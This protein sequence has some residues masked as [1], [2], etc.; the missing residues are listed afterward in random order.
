MAV[1]APC[2]VLTPLSTPPL[3]AQEAEDN[4]AKRQEILREKREK[5]QGLRGRL[6]NIARIRGAIRLLLIA[7][8]IGVWWGGRGQ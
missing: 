6:Q 8:D 4:E 3:Q 5:E 2:W 7:R 1:D